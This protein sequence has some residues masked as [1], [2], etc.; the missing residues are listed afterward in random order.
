ME[1][2]TREGNRSREN[3]TVDHIL[4][5]MYQLITRRHKVDQASDMCVTVGSWS[6]ALEFMSLVQSLTWIYSTDVLRSRQRY[7]HGAGLVR[8]LCFNLSLHP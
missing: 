8:T 3:F 6:L 1:V 2:E 5:C 7:G 4:C